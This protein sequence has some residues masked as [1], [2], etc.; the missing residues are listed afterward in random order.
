VAKTHRTIQQWNR[1]LLQFP[2]QSVLEA[3]QRFLPHLLSD[4]Y[5][6]HSLLIGV[7]N[8][9]VLLQASVTQHH[10]LL[11]TLLSHKKDIPYIE[12]QFYHLPIASGSVDLVIVPHTLEYVDNPH[13]LL[14]EACRVVRPEGHIVVCGFNPYSLWGLKKLAGQNRG[15][16]WSG[17]FIPPGTVKKWLTLADFKLE[18]QTSLLFRPPV[19]QAGIYQ[20][21][22]WMEWLGTKL[23]LPIGCIYMIVAQA[24]VIP[25]TPIKLRWKQQLTGNRLPTTISISNHHPQDL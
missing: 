10:A 7:P 17:N 11:S 8:Q 1:W 18:K 19:T 16:P 23:Q 3:E 25:L 6:K 2:G 24:K 12:G 20:N 22:A 9:Q 15:I 4:Y 21:L 14:A 13:Q 5:G